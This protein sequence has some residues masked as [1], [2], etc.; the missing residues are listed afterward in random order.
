[1][2]KYRWEHKANVFTQ[3]IAGHSYKM[4]TLGFLLAGRMEAEHLGPLDSFPMTVRTQRLRTR[5]QEESILRQLQ[6][7]V[8]GQSRV[9]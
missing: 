9:T 6:Q 3:V 2:F 8:S 5:R 4:N 1:M 7:E